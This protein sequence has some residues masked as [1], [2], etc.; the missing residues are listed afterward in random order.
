MRSI[1]RL[2][3]MPLAIA[4]VKDRRTWTSLVLKR[5]FDNEAARL[6]EDAE[7][8]NLVEVVFRSLSRYDNDPKQAK[9]WM[10]QSRCIEDWRVWK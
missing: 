10:D 1:G 5:I 6:L 2:L 3:R 4:P 7:K 8:E 9:G